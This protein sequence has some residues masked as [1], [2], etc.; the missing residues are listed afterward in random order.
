MPSHWGLRSQHRNFQGEQHLVHAG[1][2]Y[3][4][5][6]TQKCILFSVIKTSNIS[7]VCL[8]NQS[9]YLIQ[10]KIFL[11]LIVNFTFDYSHPQVRFSYRIEIEEWLEM[12]KNPSL[13][14]HA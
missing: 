7:P 10:Y 11:N 6:C 9:D 1:F 5:L 2:I 4:Y 8:F 14:S 3:K 12:R 13:N